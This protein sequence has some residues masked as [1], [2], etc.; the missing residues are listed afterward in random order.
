[1]ERWFHIYLLQGAHGRNRLKFNPQNSAILDRKQA[2]FWSQCQVY[3]RYF[4]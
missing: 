2:T 1:M 4:G 3:L